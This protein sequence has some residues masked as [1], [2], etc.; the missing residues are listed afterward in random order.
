MPDAQAYHQLKIVLRVFTKEVQAPSGPT[1][2]LDL[3]YR[4]PE[5]RNKIGD[6]HGEFGTNIGFIDAGS[7]N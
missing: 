7:G 3:L 6:V 5:Y 4:D 2:Q 1:Q